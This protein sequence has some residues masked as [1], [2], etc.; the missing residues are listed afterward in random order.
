MPY[1]GLTKAANKL[2][3]NARKAF[4]EAFNATDCMDLYDGNLEQY[5]QVIRQV[6]EERKE[7]LKEVKGTINQ[8]IEAVSCFKKKR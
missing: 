5:L 3:E 6:L 2:P 8:F 4:K 7:K 1:C